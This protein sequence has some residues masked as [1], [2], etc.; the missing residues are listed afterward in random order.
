MINDFLRRAGSLAPRRRAWILWSCLSIAAAG[1]G[2]KDDEATGPA[3]ASASQSGATVPATIMAGTS[4][5]IEVQA[6]TEDGQNM[7]TGGAVVAGTI[8]GANPGELFG[9]DNGNGSYTVSYSPV[10]EGTD[11][12]SI[13]LNDEQIGDSPF[14][15]TVTAPPTALRSR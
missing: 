5:E 12:I 2:C 10:N 9:T 15:V 1:V 6:R 7:T 4:I 11:Q 14:T 13:T 8:S 3:A